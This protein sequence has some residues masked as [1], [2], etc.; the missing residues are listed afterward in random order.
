MVTKS[1]GNR[2]YQERLIPAQR[3]QDHCAYWIQKTLHIT[4]GNFQSKDYQFKFGENIQGVEIKHDMQFAKTGNLWIEVRHR[5]NTE[6]KYYN[7]GIMRANNTW[8]YAIGNYEDLYLFSVKGLRNILN[9]KQY[10]IKSNNLDTSQGFLLSKK[11]AEYYC[12][13]KIETYDIVKKDDYKINVDIDELDFNESNANNRPNKDF[14]GYVNGKLVSF[15]MEERTF[16]KPR[17]K[18]DFADDVQKVCMFNFVIEGKSEPIKMSRM[19]GTKIN[20]EAKHIKA[21]GRGKKE[22]E[23]YNA[24]TE[25][26]IKLGIFNIQDVK[27]DNTK[28]LLDNLKNAYKTISEESPIYIKTKLERCKKSYNLENIDISTIK[29]T[30]MENKNV[31]TK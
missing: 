29:L 15:K 11:D 19:T 28:T 3:F 2:L 18:N 14:D 12:A 4:I 1:E 27:D 7:G 31:I 25:M 10:E 23:E 9:E 5:K 26:C 13:A 21:K 30:N 22:Q 20:T 8:L 6:E 16:A 17:F 24:L